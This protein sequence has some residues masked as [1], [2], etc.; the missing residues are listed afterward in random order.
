[1][2]QIKKEK[3]AP[4]PPV[5]DPAEVIKPAE[6]AMAA[7]KAT[8]QR[9]GRKASSSTSADTLSSLDVH[10]QMSPSKFL[11]STSE[12][13]TAKD[14]AQV[15]KPSSPQLSQPAVTQ[16]GASHAEVAKEPVAPVS[17]PSDTA[18]SSS[19]VQAPKS[20]SVP[21]AQDTAEQIVSSDSSESQSDD[22]R[23]VSVTPPR[24]SEPI[25]DSDEDYQ[26]EESSSS[27]E[28][29]EEQ[30]D[31]Q[32]A[33]SPDQ[34]EDEEDLETKYQYVF[35]HALR[36]EQG[37]M[38]FLSS[39]ALKKLPKSDPKRSKSKVA[40]MSPS[41]YNKMRTTC[42]YFS[43]DKEYISPAC[44]DPRFH[45]DQQKGV[46][47]EIL[48]AKAFVD[49]KAIDWDA[50]ADPRLRSL[51][52]LIQ[53]AGLDF[54]CSLQ[55][56][57][58]PEIIKEFY[59][60]VW[61]EQG[62]QDLMIWRTRGQLLSITASEFNSMF[63]APLEPHM[64]HLFKLESVPNKVRR[65]FY[66]RNFSFPAKSPADH[67]YF[68]G[69]TI[70]AKH[71]VKILNVTIQPKGGNTDAVYNATWQVLV[72]I[73]KNQHFDIAR[74]IFHEIDAV[75]K[76]KKSKMRYGS[77]IMHMILKRTGLPESAFEIA[78]KCSK[79]QLRPQ[80]D[81]NPDEAAVP[82]LFGDPTEAPVPSTCHTAEQSDPLGPSPQPQAPQRQVPTGVTAELPT[83]DTAEQVS[84]MLVS[85]DGTASSTLM[86]PVAA[87][88]YQN[89][90]VPRQLVAL[91]RENRELKDEMTALKG[92]VTD[93]HSKMDNMQIQLSEVLKLLKTK[94][95]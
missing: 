38:E 89:K 94:G 31:E 11:V 18:V 32:E 15:A 34:S 81:D 77:Y 73:A 76:D 23:G 29:E 64:P 60:T 28:S 22:G 16:T 66:P 20:P 53:A 47:H 70:T 57:Y 74:Y 68:K 85:E 82:A 13:Q 93:L 69:I 54:L 25:A 21:Q 83:D 6:V 44:S 92:E 37:Q 40:S 63:R 30:E 4:V 10:K 19:P 36:T 3:S 14:S 24:P 88:A 56:G 55:Q 2:K 33:S 65:K 87:R 51:H 59:A 41:A 61:I 67:V 52:S 8:Y 46:F 72:H 71:L 90:V 12:E 39:A 95:P 49:C 75:Q 45:N 5:S 62:N 9:K 26:A 84:V 17:Q 35:S 42:P 91:R 43:A 80:A 79:T 27:S 50:L 78:V 86:S 48:S 58:D 1:M 7:I